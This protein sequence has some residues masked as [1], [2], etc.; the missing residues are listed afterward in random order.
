MSEKKGW[1]E[2][3][4]DIFGNK[5]TRH[6][7]EHGN[8]AGWSEE[9]TGFFG[10]TYTQ[11]HDQ[12]G[13]KAGW[14]EERTGLFGDTY[15]QHHDQGDS[16]TGW[17]EERTGLFGDTYT[18]HH[19]QQG[20]KAGWSEKRTGLFGDRYTQHY[21][22]PGYTTDSSHTSSGG[23]FTDHASGGGVTSGSYDASRTGHGIGSVVLGILVLGC[24]LAFLGGEEK[25]RTVTPPFSPRSSPPSS[26]G[27]PSSPVTPAPPARQPTP[28]APALSA[29]DYVQ[30]MLSSA[31]VDGGIN[32]EGQ[33]LEAKRR[34]EQLSPRRS[35]RNRKTARALNAKGLKYN[36]NWQFAEAAQAFQQAYQADPADIEIINNLGHAHMK[37]GNGIEAERSLLETLTLVPDRS[38]A[39]ADLGQLYADQGSLSVSVACFANA[40]RFSPRKDIT[41]Q[42]LERLSRDGNER[43]REAARQALQLKLVQ[44]DIEGLAADDPPTPASVDRFSHAG[45]PSINTQRPSEDEGGRGIRSVGKR[46]ERRL[47][48]E[49]FRDV[50]VRESGIVITLS[51]DVASRQELK[52]VVEIANEEARDARY[53]LQWKVSY[54]EQNSP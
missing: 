13:S 40:Y 28:H 30:Q 36:E 49:G 27:R 26:L 19:D 50:I 24:F 38:S 22:R 48:Q 44:R 41:R 20:S 51:G 29:Q 52:R 34:V 45:A 12:Q 6:Y 21:D 4:T 1:S 17:S 35:H 11:H 9:R 8:K 15:T 37:N 39:W 32:D 53:T 47:R 16:K 23:G 3:R 42:F 54:S 18:Q 33:I 31:V 2:E 25:T 14:S 5:Y 10:D 7:D 46:L 43:E